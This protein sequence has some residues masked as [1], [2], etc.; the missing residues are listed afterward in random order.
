MHFWKANG[1]LTDSHYITYHPTSRILWLRN[2]II[3]LSS[4]KDTTENL[5]VVY[6]LL[7]L[8]VCTVLVIVTLPHPIVFMD[9]WK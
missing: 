1:P 8:Y 7:D 6:W 4:H 5:T 2:E 9:L 3:Y